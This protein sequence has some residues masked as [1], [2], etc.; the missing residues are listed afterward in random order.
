MRTWHEIDLLV[1][2]ELSLLFPSNLCGI[3]K[4][5]ASLHIPNPPYAPTLQLQRRTAQVASEFKVQPTC[6]LENAAEC[7]DYRWHGPLMV[8]ILGGPQR[9]NERVAND[10]FSGWISPSRYKLPADVEKTFKLFWVERT[11]RWQ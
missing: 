5:E 2:C 4:L 6:R 11:T 8:R 9:L 1:F 10:I 3:S 7:K